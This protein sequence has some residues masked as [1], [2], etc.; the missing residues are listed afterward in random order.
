M[1]DIIIVIAAVLVLINDARLVYKYARKGEL[2]LGLL[3]WLTIIAFIPAI[4][5]IVDF[6]SH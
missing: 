3:D 1:Y 2:K 6:F 4:S 5:N